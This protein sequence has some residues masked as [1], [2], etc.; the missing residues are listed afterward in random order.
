MTKS[1]TCS[2]HQDQEL[3]EEMPWRNAFDAWPI[4]R[5]P[6]L[7]SPASR[8]RGAELG[9]GHWIGQEPRRM[10]AAPPHPPPSAIR[11]FLRY[12]VPYLAPL[13][14]CNFVPLYT[15]PFPCTRSVIAPCY[16][17]PMLC[18]PP[19]LSPSPFYPS[20]ITLFK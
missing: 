18:S 3:V 2:G 15:H 13:Y 10:Q 8:Q 16:C 11:A 19:K 12:L 5:V 17:V 4:E 7:S 6:Q 1:E 20:T 9:A 14:F